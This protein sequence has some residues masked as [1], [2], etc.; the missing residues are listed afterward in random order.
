MEEHALLVKEVE[1]ALSLERPI[2]QN[3]GSDVE[4]LSVTKMGVIKVHLSGSCRLCRHERIATLLNIEATL[5]KNIPWIKVVIE[6]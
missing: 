3:K 2:L 4:L 1:K 5:K 6:N